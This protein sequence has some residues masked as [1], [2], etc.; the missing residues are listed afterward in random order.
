MRRPSYFARILRP[1]PDR[2][3][4]VK[5]VH[6]LLQ[7]W[8]LV[9]NPQPAAGFIS[10]APTARKSAPV[11]SPPARRT[12]SA[13]APSATPTFDAAR[14]ENQSRPP[15]ITAPESSVRSQP[16]EMASQ[17]SRAL[18]ASPAIPPRL[19]SDASPR[20]AHSS[21]RVPRPM[22]ANASF[23]GRSNDTRVGVTEPLIVDSRPAPMHARLRNVPLPDEALPSDSRAAPVRRP[24]SVPLPPRPTVLEPNPALASPMPHPDRQPRR[25]GPVRIGSI[26]IHVLPP[27]AAVQ[28]PP[29]IA[30]LPPAPPLA[31]GFTSSFG[32][33]QG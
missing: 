2:G 30:P 18:L 10:P 28:P 24:L 22:P 12:T 7:R 8:Q 1:G 16:V 33:R 4:V 14:R 17:T 5:L 3:P 26:D 11:L 13:A 9:S 29:R 20:R 32:L 25:Q 19:A 27:P 6:P 15:P 23:I 21:D 31:R